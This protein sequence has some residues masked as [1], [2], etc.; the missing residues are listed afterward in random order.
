MLYLQGVPRRHR[1]V[2]F[3]P[4]P[5]P[6]G[7]AQAAAQS[8]DTRPCP[9]PAETELDK[10]RV[11]QPKARLLLPVGR[12]GRSELSICRVEKSGCFSVSF[13]GQA[14]QLP[15]TCG[16]ACAE[17]GLGRPLDA[18][19][20]V[21][22]DECSSSSPA[23][24]EPALCGQGTSAGLQGLVNFYFVTSNMYSDTSLRVGNLTAYLS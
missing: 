16:A 1:P 21:C 5:M 12:M 22:L 14:K 17:Q 11:P 19:Q 13:P 7:D 2:A 24:W 9:E 20:P 8:S 15:R 10:P 4:Q 6:P 3:S 23:A 18:T